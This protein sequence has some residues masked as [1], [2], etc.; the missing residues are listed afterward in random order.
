MFK[1]QDAGKSLANSFSEITMHKDSESLPVSQLYELRLTTGE[2]LAIF[3]IIN[4]Y[5][6]GQLESTSECVSE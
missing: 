6:Q 1:L 2:S 5:A 3:F 4:H